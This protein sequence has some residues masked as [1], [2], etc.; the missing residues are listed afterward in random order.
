[1]KLNLPWRLVVTTT[2]GVVLD[3]A[4]REIAFCDKE[5]VERV[6]GGIQWLNL[7]QQGAIP[8]GETIRRIHPCQ[9]GESEK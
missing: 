3:S 2:G 7:N 4:R 8:A 9:S 5:H 1:M 6:A